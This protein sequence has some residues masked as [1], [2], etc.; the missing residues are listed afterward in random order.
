M[1]GTDAPKKIFT[2]SALSFSVSLFKICQGGDESAGALLVLMGM[3]QNSTQP[4]VLAN[5]AK[6]LA[7]TRC[8]ELNLYGMVDT[9]IAAVESKLF[10]SN[11]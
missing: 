9:Q 5:T 2:Y 8:G 6:Y 10:A 11:A 4:K 3:I 7:C 1:R